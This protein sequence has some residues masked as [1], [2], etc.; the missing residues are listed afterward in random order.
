M[1]HA[2]VHRAP[3]GD[4]APAAGW[5][6]ELQERGGATWGRVAWNDSGRQAISSKSYRYYSPTYM[7]SRP[8]SRIARIHSVGLVNTPNLDVPALN[9]RGGGPRCPRPY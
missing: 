9:Q 7:V 6:E 4:A 2:Q 8:A 5:V 1:N 3:L